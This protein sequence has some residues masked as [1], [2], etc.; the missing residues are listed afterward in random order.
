M[1]GVWWTR[2][3]TDRRC[4]ADLV[5]DA[6]GRLSRLAP[7]PGA[8]RRH[9]HGLRVS[10]LPQTCGR[11]AWTVD[12]PF[13]WSGTFSGYDSYVFPHEHGHVSAVIIRP[14]A[15]AGLGALRHLD[16]F[17]AACR[18]PNPATAYVAEYMAMAASPASLPPS[19]SLATCTDRL[20]PPTAEGPTRHHIVALAEAA[21]DGSVTRLMRPGM[22]QT[23][24]HPTTGRGERANERFATRRLRRDRLWPTARK[25]PNE[26]RLY[27]RTRVDILGTLHPDRRVVE[28][29]SSTAGGDG[30]ERCRLAAAG[31]GRVSE[32]IG[33]NIEVPRS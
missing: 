17:N 28:P 2:S 6:S 4:G 26:L 9:R 19:R 18:P 14:T 12:Q 33:A 30:Y 29:D 13:A 10:D 7:A 24:R 23:G 20:A 1:A 8:R 31:A 25:A 32:A 15:D 5:I 3:W 27:P 21:Q 22:P 11:S 16:A